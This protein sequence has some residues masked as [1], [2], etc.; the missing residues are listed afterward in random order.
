MLLATPHIFELIQKRFRFLLPQLTDLRRG[1]LPLLDH[2]FDLIRCNPWFLALV[3]GVRR[4]TAG[5][6]TVV[7]IKLY[8]RCLIG[9]ENKGV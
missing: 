6:E 5:W 3:A 2:F 7:R 8:L 4:A 9:L 1:Q